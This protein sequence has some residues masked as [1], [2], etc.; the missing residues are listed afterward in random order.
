MAEEN[1]IT[2]QSYID[3]CAWL[4]PIQPVC[5][6]R[7][8]RL[9][10]ESSYLPLIALAN[11]F[12][13]T[14]ALAS[15]LKNKG[16]WIKLPTLLSEYLTTLEKGYLERSLAIQYETKKVCQHLMNAGH[17]LVLIKGA[18]SLFNGVANPISTRFM[19]DIDILVR[20]KEIDSAFHILL[21][22]D[23]KNAL[24]PHELHGKNHHHKPVLKREEGVCY[25]ELHQWPVKSEYE[26]LL[27][28]DNVWQKR[29]P[30]PLCDE[31]QVSQLSAEQQI[32]LTIVHSELSD[33]GIKEQHL[34]LRQLYH[35]VVTAEH[36][37][38]QIDWC[39]IKK[40]FV[41]HGQE[42]AI[43]AALYAAYK[44]FGLVTPITD[45]YDKWAQQHLSSCIAKYIESQGFESRS[46]RLRNICKGYS[47]KS[48]L[49]LYGDDGDWPALSGRLKHAKRHFRLLIDKVCLGVVKYSPFH[50]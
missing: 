44:L 37:D 5:E 38:K 46:D 2:H 10:K 36:Y 25:V 32:I 1:K 26:N 9:K 4:A 39:R 43:N 15:Q 30:L 28:T 23:Y 41:E 17:E 27:P 40:H 7:L 50:D 21:S 48:I 35:L 33:R 14:G 16:V 13:L 19:S 45:P 29:M 34:E 42:K 49:A 6:Q 11:N 20:V 47:K 24:K 22:A 3:L 8:S 18:A 31:L 12:W